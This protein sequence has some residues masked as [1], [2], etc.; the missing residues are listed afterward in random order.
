MLGELRDWKN[1]WHGVTLGIAAAEIPHLIAMLEM[2]RDDPDQH[3][4]I[5][6]DCKGEGG[7]G[8]IE[9]YALSATARH[10]MSVSEPAMG[11]GDS[12]P[13]RP[14]SVEKP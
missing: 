9:V 1:G 11:P 5:S 12:I 13:D 7:I 3:F 2:I 8:D 10:N 6:S 14:S 4:H